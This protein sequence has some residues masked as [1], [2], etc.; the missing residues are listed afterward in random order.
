[1]MIQ[2]VDIQKKYEGFQLNCSMELEEGCITGVVGQNGAGKTTLFKAILGLIALD[3]GEVKVFGKNPRQLEKEE[4]ECIGAALSSG[5]FSEYLTL[6]EVSGICKNMYTKF[7][8][9]S[10]KEQCRQFGLPM[11]RKIKT[12]SSGMRAKAKVIIAMGHQ[13]K[14]LILDEPTAGLD[15]VARDEILE[16]MR[17]YMED[18]E[19]SIL[20]SSH[21][22]SDL[23]GL[24][25]DIYMI[26]KGEIV[27]H[28][29]TDNL[30]AK[31]GLIKVDENQYEKLDKQY[32][33]RRKKESFG[34][35]CLTNERQF[36]LENY[37]KIVVEKGN[38]DEV[39]TMTIKGERV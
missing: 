26:H 10:F 19:R 21:I 28:E 16:L 25:D 9:N 1:M 37:P 11:D 24:C 4:K 6:G 33:L 17:D 27:L 29:E 35:S 12:F 14:L 22:Y 7:N 32:L 2:A 18:G 13:A 36:Y 39:I 23:E 30:L 20:I 31:Y 5:S 38:I 34:Y 8:E 3:G 15:V